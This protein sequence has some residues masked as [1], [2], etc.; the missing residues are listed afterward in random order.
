MLICRVVG[1]AVASV[2]REELVNYKLLI[3]QEVSVENE[4][5]GEAF[6]AIDT[7]G[8]GDGEVVV[9]TRGSAAGADGSVAAAQR[10]VPIDAS[11]VGILDSLSVN[12][13]MTFKK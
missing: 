3:V 6:V 4:L 8:A 2:K 7:V 13:K 11:I 1:T 12:G 10:R 9:V 5:K